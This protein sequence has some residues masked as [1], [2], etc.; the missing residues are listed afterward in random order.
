[1]LLGFLTGLIIRY[2]PDHLFNKSQNLLIYKRSKE[3]Q[4]VFLT[5]HIGGQL[6][7]ASSVSTSLIINKKDLRVIMSR[8]LEWNKRVFMTDIA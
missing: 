7:S 3:V 6:I 4:L 1:L 5:E 8:V 2:F